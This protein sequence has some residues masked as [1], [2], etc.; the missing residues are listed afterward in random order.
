M[1]AS[2]G[3]RQIGPLVIA[4]PGIDPAVS[5]SA[6]VLMRSLTHAGQFAEQDPEGDP[7][8]RSV[9]IIAA[10]VHL[11]VTATD[12]YRL[13]AERIDANIEV[14]DFTVALDPD[15]VA[16]LRAVLAS[17]L[18][19][20]HA[21]DDLTVR[22]RLVELHDSTLLRVMCGRGAADIEPL[23][24]AAMR[25]LPDWR[26]WPAD[27]IG[28]FDA[29]LSTDTLAMLKKIKAVDKHDRGHVH[30]VCHGQR[31]TATFP[32]GETVIFFQRR[33]DPSFT[34]S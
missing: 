20:T 4:V 11:D 6:R 7:F 31:I 29:H 13:F 21:S 17:A 16:V 2:D 14:D 18:R 23:D 8:L 24:P 1:T 28:P 34:A 27:A 22:L 30:L 5:T 10:G 32:D 9:H 12:R 26:S 33:L 25:P 19:S 3:E 15:G